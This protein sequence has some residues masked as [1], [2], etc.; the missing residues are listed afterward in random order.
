MED[1]REKYLTK[2][3]TVHT[4]A[5]KEDLILGLLSHFILDNIIDSMDRVNKYEMKA[6][7]TL[8]CQLLTYVNYCQT[9]SNL[10]FTWNGNYLSHI[11]SS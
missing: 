7:D 4:A 5:K 8:D 1:G 11:H 10:Y 6:L 3:V 2:D 9:F